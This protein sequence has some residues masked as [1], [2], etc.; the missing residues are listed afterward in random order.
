MGSKKSQHV[1]EFNV[2][3]IGV[4]GQGV[5]TMA[6]IIS[7]AALKQGYAPEAR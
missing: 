3:A 1:E 4:G 2:V 6:E 5:L 7:E